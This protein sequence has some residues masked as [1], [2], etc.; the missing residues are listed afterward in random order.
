[1]SDPIYNLKERQWIP[2]KE[3]KEY[4]E[5]SSAEDAAAYSEGGYKNSWG[6]NE[7]FKK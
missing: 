2:A 4:R 1:M 5:F 3:T 7:I 6:R